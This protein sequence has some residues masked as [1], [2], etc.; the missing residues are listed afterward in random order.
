[1]D[2][3]NPHLIAVKRAKVGEAV[4]VVLG[5]L[6][7]MTTGCPYTHALGFFFSLF[8]WPPKLNLAAQ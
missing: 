8:P 3:I 1:M 2:I 7:F 4:V 6:V 5:L